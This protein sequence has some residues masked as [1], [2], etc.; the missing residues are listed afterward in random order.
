M[1]YMLSILI[2]FSLEIFSQDKLTLFVEK[3]I[4]PEGDFDP[5]INNYQL[6][7]S[8]I[9]NW[10]FRNDY[11]DEIKLL[12]RNYI[13]SFQKKTDINVFFI[14]PTTLYSS[15]NWNSDTSSFRKDRIIKLSLQNQASCF[16]GICNIYAPNYRQMHI[17]SYIDTING[18]KAYDLAYN[19]ILQ[20]FKYFINYLNNDNYFILAGHSQ[21]TNH[22]MRLINEYIH[23]DKYISDKL[24]LSY[25]IGMDVKRSFSTIPPCNSED[26]LFCFLSWRT[27]AEN[28]Y[29]DNWDYG[30]H[31]FS[32]NP[33]SW[34]INED[35][36]FF[37][38]HMGILLPNKRLLFKNTLSVFNKDGLLFL[39]KPK[40]FL[41]NLYPSKNYHPGDFNLYWE[42]IRDN[43]KIR[44][45]NLN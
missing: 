42:N 30:N 38:D 22:A 35:E 16:S 41:L 32:I 24:L 45:S 5:T 14:H 43:L 26:D 37:K 11:D 34:D 7:Y 25:L 39:K 6:D 18:Y 15:N 2:I 31:I 23:Y 10:A 20:A 19:D 12:P 21:G 13:D 1:K 33:I 17:Y 27:F 9:K 44:L 29:P 28:N 8:K 40:N 4:T 3:E 36:S